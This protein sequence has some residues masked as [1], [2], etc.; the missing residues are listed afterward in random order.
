MVFMNEVINKVVSENDNEHGDSHD[1]SQLRSSFAP[2][3]TMFH[4]HSS[5]DQSKNIYGFNNW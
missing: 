4:R 3:E 5:I 2:N 1:F